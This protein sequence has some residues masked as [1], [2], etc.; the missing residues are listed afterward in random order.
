MIK[1]YGVHGSPFVRKVF[2]ALTMKNVPFEVVP[3]MPFAGDTEYLT[4]NPLGKIPTLVDD[5]LVL[6]DSKVI[7]QYLEEA[8]PEPPLYP[9]NA[10]DRA[11]ARWFEELAAGKLAELVAGIFFQRYMRP[12]VLKQKPDEE[13]I[14]N[15]IEQKLP[16]ILDYLE[17]ELPE[18]GFMFGDF[19][20]ADLSVVGPFINAGYVGFEVNS[21]CWPKTARLI[22]AVQAVH[23]VAA[24]IAEE[25][26]ALGVS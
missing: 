25:K 15:I 14:A 1:V 6:G 2:I 7:C 21:D 20:M 4:I 5:N 13:F 26:K 19:G 23:V 9:Q 18:N 12:M 8:Y 22:R 3:Q 17:H 11:R 24:I 16:P 10:Q